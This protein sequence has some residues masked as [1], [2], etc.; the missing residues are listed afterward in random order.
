MKSILAI[1]SISYRPSL[2]GKYFA[3]TTIIT[4]ISLKPRLI[5]T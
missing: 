3:A 2:L 1:S 5:I 4:T